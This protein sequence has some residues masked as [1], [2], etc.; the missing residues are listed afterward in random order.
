MNGSGIVKFDLT[1]PDGKRLFQGVQKALAIGFVVFEA[2]I[3]VFTGG[4]APAE[5][6]GPLLIIF[7]LALGGFLILFMDEV[8]SKWGFGQGISLFI[9]AQVSKEIMVRLLNPLTQQ[10]EIAFLSSS[11]EPPIGALFAIFH[12]I[13]QGD[14]TEVAVR[15]AA[16]LATVF[17]FVIAVYA[18]AMKVEVPLSMGRVR[19]HG[20]RWPLAF[21]YTSVIPVILTA[22]LLANVQLGAAALESKDIPLLGTYDPQTG[23]ATGLVAWLTIPDVVEGLIRGT[24]QPIHLARAATYALF[25]ICGAV[26]FSIFWVKDCGNGRKKPGKADDGLWAADTGLQKRRAGAGKPA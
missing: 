17:V 18:Q 21:I 4:L 10:G 8:I 2:F 15:V 19:G 23:D 25:L 1:S 22:A 11:S 16:I 24:A 6:Y 7:Q 5:G 14:I 13:P 3:Y 9:A 20:I 12:F 26:L